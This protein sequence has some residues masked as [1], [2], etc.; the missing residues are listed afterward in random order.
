MN[1]KPSRPLPTPIG[2]QWA[3][4]W[5][6]VFEGEPC[7]E[8][9][10]PDLHMAFLAGASSVLEILSDPPPQVVYPVPLDAMLRVLAAEI[11]ARFTPASSAVEDD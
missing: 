11:L 2:D 8:L 4:Y 10:K 7:F 1:A 3:S 9:L 5:R 6:E